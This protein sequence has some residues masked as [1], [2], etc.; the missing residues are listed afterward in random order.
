MEKRSLQLK[1]SS[2]R[3]RGYHPQQLRRKMTTEGKILTEDSM[4]THTHTFLKGDILSLKET[5]IEQLQ[6]A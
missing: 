2:R 3:E 1:K 4:E 5:E 6:E